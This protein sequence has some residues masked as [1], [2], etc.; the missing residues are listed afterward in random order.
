MNPVTPP[1]T[2]APV[3]LFCYM[4]PEHLA[5]T[6]ESLRANPLAAQT[7]LQVY[8][9]AARKPEHQAGVNAVR[10]FV[11]TI[12]GFASVRC[13]LRE[14]NLGLARSIID[15]VS[16]M[17]RQHD[18]VIVLEDDMVLSPHF[19]AYMNGALALYAADAQ[20]ASIH[21]YCYPV[22]QALPETF[23]L[24]G[25]DCWGWA[26]WS[27]AWAHFEP[28]GARLL[29][30]LQRQGLTREFDLDGSYPYTAMLRGQIAGRNDSWAIRWHASCYLRGL[31]TLYP[32]RS[33]V[34][35][36]GNDASGTHCGPTEV[37]TGT[38]DP[39][40][41]DLQRIPLA[42]SEAGRAAF[43]GFFRRTRESLPR[44]VLRRIPRLLGMAR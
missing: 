27:R 12:T 5:R 4:R 26:T 32:G 11:A 18:R 25:A 41:V 8:C 43:V 19:L 35:N 1:A 33:L 37:Y 24:R 2:P 15:G 31:L 42:P 9:D 21:G 3:V 20:V 30:E 36:I 39:R 34:V 29:G 10:A 16:T 28:D 44:R 6:V 40:P 13:V 38:L 7:H 22:Q 17:L 23:F 14:Q